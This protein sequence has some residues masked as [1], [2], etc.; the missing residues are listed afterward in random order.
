MTVIAIPSLGP[1]KSSLLEAEQVE[2]KARSVSVV[3][4][5]QGGTGGEET[6]GLGKE[7]RRWGKGEEVLRGKQ[8]RSKFA[9]TTSSHGIVQGSR[10]WVKAPRERWEHD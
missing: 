1:T 3:Y 6:Q 5:T 4:T 9:P 7:T 10:K 2:K 8:R